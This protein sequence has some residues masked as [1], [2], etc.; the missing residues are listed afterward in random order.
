MSAATAASPVRTG[1][2]QVMIADDSA[3]VRGMLTRWMDEVTDL[4]MIGYAPDGAQAIKRVAELQ[5]ELL[6]LDVEMPVMGGLEALPGLLKACPGLQIVMASTLTTQGGKVAL[7]ALDLGAVDYVAKPSASHLGGANAYRDDLFEKLRRLG[8]SSRRRAASRYAYS[9][10][11]RVARPVEA[12][13]S[14]APAR[15]AI[16]T[17]A[18]IAP[19]REL[20]ASIASHPP[21]E[22]AVL[23]LAASTGGPP[24]LKTFL[25]SLGPNWPTP[26]LIVQHMP[27]NF[28]PVLAEQLSKVGG[29]SVVEAKDGMRIEAGH[30]YLAPGGWH[31]R[32]ANEE[33]RVVTKL[34]QGP[35]ENYCRPAA[36]P[37]FRSAAALFGRRV[38]GVVMTG[39]G[40]DGQNG[41][42]VV[43]D[44]GGRVFAQDE[45]SSVVWGMP[46]SV[47][48][49]GLA[50]KVAPVDVLA[51]SA[52]VTVRRSAAR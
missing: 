5:P 34:D 14:P 18:S 48:N 28:T 13:P 16:A 31:M 1:P 11:S 45:A 10:T 7:E 19:R 41:S 17:A 39:M 49:A 46:G 23:L 37:L 44:A 15:S 4:K 20:A 50:S 40:K 9:Q 47:V 36:D 38:L 8:E 6:I 30:A 52:L 29:P 32:L 12:A 26:I 22:P 51:Q 2:F 27:A 35:E 42:Q 33:G 21:V 3:I 43:T 25:K 24:A